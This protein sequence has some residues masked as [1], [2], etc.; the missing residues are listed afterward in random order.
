MRRLILGK[1]YDIYYA[2]GMYTKA[3]ECSKQIT[4]IKDEECLLINKDYSTYHIEKYRNDI[5]IRKL[6]EM[7]LRAY[8]NLVII[9]FIVSIIVIAVL[10]SNKKL[11]KRNKIDEMSEI[12]NRS[13]FDKQYRKMLNLYLLNDG[14]KK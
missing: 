4:Q 3:I 10:L 2:Q 7:K 14:G 5:K 13:Y 6:G 8:I 1:M 12:N 9:I 11:R